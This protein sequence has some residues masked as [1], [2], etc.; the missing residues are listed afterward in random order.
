MS[1]LE[2]FLV[3][4]LLELAEPAVTRPSKLSQPLSF[5]SLG[6]GYLLIRVPKRVL[7]LPNGRAV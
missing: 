3:T 5:F 6:P 2:C 1:L 4:L 7:E